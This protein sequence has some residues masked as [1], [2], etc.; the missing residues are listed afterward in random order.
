M[1]RQTFH[2]TLIAGG[3][4]ELFLFGISPHKSASV[5]ECFPFI[6]PVTPYPWMWRPAVVLKSRSRKLIGL[7]TS[8]RV[9][10][11][12]SLIIHERLLRCQN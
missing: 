12:K 4:R 1:Q 10:R 9:Q 5:Y 3:T 8:T 7:G 11:E 6:L 2:F